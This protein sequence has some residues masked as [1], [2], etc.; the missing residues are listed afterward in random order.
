M[1]L[2]AA[3]QNFTFDIAGIGSV[4]LINF[5]SDQVGATA[6]SIETKGLKFEPVVAAD[7]ALQTTDVSALEGITNLV[8]MQGGP[9]T[10]PY[11]VSATQQSSSQYSL[12][13]NVSQSGSWALVL[14]PF[15]DFGTASVETRDLS[16]V[17][18]IVAGLSLSAGTGRVKFQVEDANGGRAIV[19]L[20]NVNTTEQFYRIPINSLQNVDLAHVKNINFVVE[21]GRVPNSGQLNIRLG[22]HPYVI[23][24]LPD[25]SLTTS[26]L[27]YLP[28]NPQITVVSTT[29]ATASASAASGGVEVTYNTGTAGWAGGGL[30]FDNFGTPAF[31]TSDLTG[32]EEFVFSLKGDSSTVKLEFVDADNRRASVHLT[33]IVPDQEKIFRIPKDAFKNVNLA[34]MR[35]VYIII[36]GINQQGKVLFCHVPVIPAPQMTQAPSPLNGWQLKWT[37]IANALYE[38]QVSNNLLNWTLA[39]KAVSTGTVTTW[40]DPDQGQTSPRYYR[41]VVK[42]LVPML[43]SGWT[44][45]AS[46]ANFAYQSSNTNPGNPMAGNEVLK[47]QDLRTGQL[48]TVYNK[49]ATEEDLWNIPDV[50]SDGKYV[51]FATRTMGSG[52]KAYV[53]DLAG[54]AAAHEFVMTTQA[55]VPNAPANPYHFTATEIQIDMVNASTMTSVG[56]YK[57]NTTTWQGRFFPLVSSPDK[58]HFVIQDGNYLVIYDDQK[59]E[60]GRFMVEEQQ[61]RL[62]GF[63]V[64]NDRVYA[65]YNQRN[66]FSLEYVEYSDLTQRHAVTMPTGVTPWNASA[67]VFVSGTDKAYIRGVDRVLYLVDLKNSIVLATGVNS[68]DYAHT[69][70]KIGAELVIYDCLVNELGRFLVEAQQV[71]LVSF[72]VI[73]DGIYVVY[74]QRGN[75]AME[76]RAYTALQTPQAV[77]LPAGVVPVNAS[78][79]RFVPGEAKAYI[80]ATDH[81]FYLVDLKLGII[82]ETWTR[83]ISNSNFVYRIYN[84][85][86]SNPMAGN[87]V[88]QVQDVRTLQ[89]LTVYNKPATEEDLWNIPDVSSDGKYMVFATRTMG[90]GSK[91]YVYDLAGTAAAHEFVMTTLAWVPNAPANPYHFTAAEIQIDMVNAS[92]MTSVGVYKI[93]TTTWQGVLSP[94]VPTG[95]TRAASNANF[96]LQVQTS[97]L[98]QVLVAKN[99]LTGAE[100]KV[101]TTPLLSK[102]GSRYDIAA[103]GKT[104]FYSITKSN[105]LS[106]TAVAQSLTDPLKKATLSGIVTSVQFVNG[107]W[108]LKINGQ[109]VRVDSV[110]FRL[111]M[112]LIVQEVA[113]QSMQLV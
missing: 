35:I 98:S 43:P 80:D 63:D 84:T 75:A 39:G 24:L 107:Y 101:A 6:Y 33:G 73:N 77:I 53:Y 48:T 46:N 103:D 9:T 50:S 4:G 45:A 93:N 22:G 27:S 47:V 113:L 95:W 62:L 16:G 112:N 81:K 3:Q 87:E 85:N 56:V 13:Y 41:V 67:L 60:L 97:G 37:S 69:V 106:G 105:G 108:V 29:G 104:V 15:D 76:Y 34:K 49:P 102:I 1:T 109:M 11:P 21:N 70:I 91:A 78:S 71:S 66:N 64:T 18:S 32:F 83:S 20:S 44:R 94:N 23:P 57:I 52:S 10:P 28:A 100:T 17:S 12:L 79:I 26:Q 36:E 65:H 111:S 38:I 31:E 8:P 19:W 72:N 74:N 58:K 90:S 99:L 82:L 2:G 68:P 55:W 110:T 89:A 54:T 5:V 7:G 25:P 96:A 51:V 92:T 30:T 59:H 61:V 14:S 42:N 40:T 88:L 86:S